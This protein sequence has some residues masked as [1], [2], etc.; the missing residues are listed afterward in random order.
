MG[1]WRK[2]RNV[3]K[4]VEKL[5]PMAYVQLL[6]PTKL[7]E[8]TD[9]LQCDLRDRIIGQDKAIDEVLE[10]YQTFISGMSSSNRPVG[11]FLFLGPTGS[12]K[13]RTVESIAESLHGDAKMVLKI[14]CSELQHSHEIAKLTGS[15]SGYL[16][17]RETKAL[18]S[19]E[20]LASHV[21]EHSKL[22]LV[23]FDEIEKGSDA[24]WNLLLGV[25]DKATLTMGDNTRTDFRNSLIFMTSNLGASEMEALISPHLGFA[26]NDTEVSKHKVENTAVGAARKRFSPEFIN[27]LDRLVVFRALTADDLRKVLNIEIK[28]VQARIPKNEMFSFSLTDEAKEFLISEGTDQKYGARH[29]K[30]AIEKQLVH[31]LAN[32]IASHQVIANDLIRVEYAEDRKCLIFL[33]MQNESAAAA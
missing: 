22:S 31:P 33:K 5:K 2:P 18:L 26:P 17:H 15:P 11:I 29:L 10:V 13:T 6:D 21:S 16:G 7:G 25:L 19:R 9:K 28:A 8:S 23:L 4:S 32:L 1:I 14:D 20:A 27:R 12:G 30:R 24:L 3:V